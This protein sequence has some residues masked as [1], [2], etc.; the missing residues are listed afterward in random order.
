MAAVPALSD[1][2]SLAAQGLPRGLCLECDWDFGPGG[3]HFHRITGFA[4]MHG[5]GWGDGMHIN[6]LPGNCDVVHGICV[7]ILT[8][9]HELTREISAAVATN[10]IPA[11]AEFAAM[12]SVNLHA[13]R[14]AIQVVGCDGETITGH[15]PVDQTLLAAIEAATD[16]ILQP[17]A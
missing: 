17:D 12:P 2:G 10:D 16:E 8:D 3:S 9:A 13:D 1:T 7:V 4:V 15:V 5:D 6:W 11:W 14:S